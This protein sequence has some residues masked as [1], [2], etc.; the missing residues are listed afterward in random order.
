MGKRLL[1]AVVLMQAAG[2]IQRLWSQ[3]PLL[4]ICDLLHDDPTKL[5]GKVIKLRGLLAITEEET[6][7]MDECEAHLVTK[8]LSWGNTVSVSVDASDKDSLRSWEKI[9][10]KLRVL[11]ADLEHDKVWVTVIGRI[12]TRASMDDEVV[13]RPYG[14]AKAGFGH[15][16]EAPAEIKMISVE[17]VEV[18]RPRAKKPS[19]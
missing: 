2:L 4:T 16:G 6:S 14:F 17:S 7:L 9:G 12:E 3:S 5:N 13:R 11:R 19:Q 1:T 15:L 8:G 18:E 10:E